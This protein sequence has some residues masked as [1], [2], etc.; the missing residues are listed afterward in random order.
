MLESAGKLNQNAGFSVF[1]KVINTIQ[2]FFV[3][4]PQS[5]FVEKYASGLKKIDVAKEA[6]IMDELND[7]NIE[8]VEVE[9]HD[10]MEDVEESKTNI[11]E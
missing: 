1:E 8:N 6:E 2:S 9:D 3:H 11:A 7:Q 5:E 4:S 10:E